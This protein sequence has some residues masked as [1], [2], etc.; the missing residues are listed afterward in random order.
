[1][2]EAQTNTWGAVV[3]QTD[4]EIYAY[5]DTHKIGLISMISLISREHALDY[6]ARKVLRAGERKR[7]DQASALKD[8]CVAAYDYSVIDIMNEPPLT[9]DRCRDELPRLCSCWFLTSP[10]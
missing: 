2:K 8:F 6:K 1:M 7:W 5:F 3:S 10:Y 4:S 9:S